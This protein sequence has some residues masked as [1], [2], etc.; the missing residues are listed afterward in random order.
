L[1]DAP[2]P[3]LEGGRTFWSCISWI[4]RYPVRHPGEGRGPAS[5]SLDSGLRRDDGL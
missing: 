3:K 5:T 2:V 4:A 1:V